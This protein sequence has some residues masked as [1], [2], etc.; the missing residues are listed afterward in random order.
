MLQYNQISGKTVK[1]DFFYFL[2]NYILH[3]RRNKYN[4]APLLHFFVYVVGINFSMVIG[5]TYQ[6]FKDFTLDLRNVLISSLIRSLF[7]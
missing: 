5:N 1:I 6:C 3:F 2:N 7:K 4:R